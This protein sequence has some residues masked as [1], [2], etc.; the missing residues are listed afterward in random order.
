MNY[1]DINDYEL[2]YMVM[3]KDEDYVNLIYDKYKPLIDKKI[4]K[5]FWISNCLNYEFEDLQQDLYI[6]I[7]KYIRDFNMEHDASFYT[8]LNTCIDRYFKDRL[9][10]YNRHNEFSFCSLDDFITNEKKS[11]FVESIAFND[12]TLVGDSDYYE[13]ESELMKF[14]YDLPINY[15]SVF[16]LFLNGYMV[17][18]ISYLIGTEIKTVYGILSKIRK[19]LKESY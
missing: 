18:E 13:L 3:D 19:K 15:A 8:Y 17:S 11:T 14:C 6:L 5:W 12:Y 2:L 16:E 1:K 10:K 9:K 7:S 4:N